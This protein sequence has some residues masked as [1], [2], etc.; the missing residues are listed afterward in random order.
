L[1][2]DVRVRSSTRSPQPDERRKAP[3]TIVA[4]YAKAL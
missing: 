3:D 1:R 4:F 2:G